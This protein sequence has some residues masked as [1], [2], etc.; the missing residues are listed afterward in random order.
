MDDDGEYQYRIMAH[1]E[2]MLDAGILRNG[3]VERGRDG[4]IFQYYLAG[5]LSGYSAL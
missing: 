4:K 1:I 5:V 3:L 2:I